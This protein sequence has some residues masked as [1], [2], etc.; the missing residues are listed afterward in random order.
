MRHVG[1]KLSKCI[2][3][4]YNYVDQLY[5]KLYVNSNSTYIVGTV[6]KIEKNQ[7]VVD[8]I[9]RENIKRQSY[10]YTW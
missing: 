2:Y 9:T 4:K 7:I 10:C 1:E 3:K 6:N 8:I 5:I